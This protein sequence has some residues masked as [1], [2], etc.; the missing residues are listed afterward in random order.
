MG[1]SLRAVRLVPQIIV[2]ERVALDTTLEFYIITGRVTII[3]PM[4]RIK[5]PVLL[6][7][8]LLVAVLVLTIRIS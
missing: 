6:M 4:L 2:S 3:L 5:V 8:A 7:P 1:L